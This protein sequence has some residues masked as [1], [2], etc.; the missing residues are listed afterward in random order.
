MLQHHRLTIILSF[1]WN[2]QENNLKK[3][4][5]AQ[6]VEREDPEAHALAEMGL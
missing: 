4:E 2:K 6:K 3:Q 5:A 1:L